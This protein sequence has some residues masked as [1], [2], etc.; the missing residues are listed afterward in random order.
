MVELIA[1]FMSPLTFFLVS[2]E[3]ERKNPKQMDTYHSVIF[4]SIISKFFLLFEFKEVNSQHFSLSSAIC[5]KY[6][7]MVPF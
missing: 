6:H 2:S 1:S 4:N 3:E 7:F 5:L